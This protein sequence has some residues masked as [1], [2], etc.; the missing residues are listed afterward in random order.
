MSGAA[1]RVARRGRITERQREILRRVARG[2]GAGGLIDLKTLKDEIAPDIGRNS[3]Y[4]AIDRMEKNGWVS[5]E[6]FAPRDGRAVRMLDIT[7]L[8]RSMI[9]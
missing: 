7:A 4:F 8:G 9:S 2:D 6:G 3:F 1:N 5:R